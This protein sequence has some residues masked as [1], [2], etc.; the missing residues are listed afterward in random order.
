MNFGYL[1]IYRGYFQFP[2]LTEEICLPKT[3]YTS[4]FINPL[5]LGHTRP[6]LTTVTADTQLI[7]KA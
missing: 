7:Q 5:I 4:L 1:E 6:A 2:L 3:L